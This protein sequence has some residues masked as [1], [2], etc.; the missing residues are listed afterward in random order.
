M[1]GYTKLEIEIPDPAYK[2]LQTLQE[3]SNMSKEQ[4]IVILLSQ[5]SPAAL[6]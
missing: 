5:A 3:V 1:N 4:I 6:Y 2:W